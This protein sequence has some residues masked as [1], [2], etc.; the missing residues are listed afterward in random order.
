MAPI[1][2]AGRHWLARFRQT[3]F[4]DYHD[5]AFRLWSLLFLVGAVA[6]GWAIL[7]IS[8]QPLLLP[9]VIAAMCVSA[10]AAHLPIRLPRAT[11]SVSLAD[12]AVFGSLALF[13]LP[14]AC[15]AAVADAVVASW[16]TST[17]VS[18]RLSS[19]A[20][21]ASSMVVAGGVFKLMEVGGS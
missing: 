15:L 3:S 2:R 4:H 19:P 9:M 21:A 12:L 5:Q 7:A 16:K 13:G 18:S 11:I 20:I 8:Q 1:A 10:L 14:A 17:R 6:L